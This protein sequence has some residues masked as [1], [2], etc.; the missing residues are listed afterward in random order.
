MNVINIIVLSLIFILV[1]VG[2]ETVIRIKKY[3]DKSIDLV[4][5]SLIK[6]INILMILTVLIGIF[7]IISVIIKK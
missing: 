7:S 5:N 3:E 2:I 1:I 6:R 4:R